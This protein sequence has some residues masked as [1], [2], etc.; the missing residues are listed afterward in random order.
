RGFE[1]RRPEEHDGE[2]RRSGPP[3]RERV[4]REPTDLRSFDGS[5]RRGRSD[6]WDLDNATW[7]PDADLDIDAIEEPRASRREPS[8]ERRPARAADRPVRSRSPREE[9]P[10]TVESTEP[11]AP[12]RAPPPVPAGPTRA[13]LKAAATDTLQTGVQTLTVTEDEADMRVDRFLA[14]RFPQLSFSYIQRIVRKGELRVNGRRVETKDR[15]EAGQAVRVPPLKLDQ[16]RPMSAKVGEDVAGFLASITLYEDADVMV[17]SKPAGLAVQGGSGTKKHL[18][19]MLAV[20]TD[21]DGQRPRL[22]HRLDKD[23][24]GCLLVAKSRFAAAALAKTFRTRAARKIYWSVVA[25]VPKPRQGR[26]STYLAKEEREDESFMR[27]AKHGEKG[28][29]HAVSYYA[30]I[31]TM[32]QKLSWLSMKPVTG[33]THQLRVH[34]AEIGH[35]IL[36]DP[37]YF[38]VENW[39]VPGGIQHKLHLH[40]RRIVVPHPRGKGTIDVSAPLPPHM[41]QTFNLLGWD[42][43]RYDPIVEAPEE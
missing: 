29:S 20:L 12:R 40:A 11:R 16:A 42:V 18:D 28:A 9:A 30:V 14:A 21:E 41:E 34:A 36:G 33:R 17:L 4:R 39:E 26:V 31:D 8:D 2:P 7:A 10:R 1:D 38:D 22:V 23:T 6:D 35:P 43:S 32:A 25:G 37:K 3:R 24:S 5:P 15:L 19:G 13:E 27:I